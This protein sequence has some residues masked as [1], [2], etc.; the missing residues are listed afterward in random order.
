MKTILLKLSGPLQAWGVESHFETRQ[1]DNYPSK[2]AIIGLIAG[3][4][5]YR[6]E[7]EK[8]LELNKLDFAV[9]IDQKGVILKDFQTAKMYT[10]KGDLKR[11]YVTNRYY[12]QDAMFIVAISSE[13]E[14]LMKNIY[15]ALK[16]PYFQPFLGKRS[17]PLNADFLFDTTDLNAVESLKNLPWQAKKW[18]Q[19]KY[20]NLNN[21]YFAE[22]Y[23]DV[24]LLPKKSYH[25]RRDNVLSFS[26]KN[27]KYSFRAEAMEVITFN[28]DKTK[29]DRVYDQA[30]DE[31][32]IFGRLED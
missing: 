10:E 20:G 26:Q 14:D 9:R 6:R 29:S 8:I 12:L 18:Y 17:L 1:T 21:Q 5:G 24:K 27:R 3:A 23:A 25:Y 11:T 28:I 15:E 31:H 30:V 22:I 16:Y 32:D 7:E 2:S 13:D 19:K 4:I